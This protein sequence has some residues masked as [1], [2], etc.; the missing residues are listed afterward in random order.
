ME[1]T[2][3]LKDIKFK[4]NPDNREIRSISHD[5]RH[6]N[7]GALFIAI[8][9]GHAD[10]HDFIDDAIQSGAVAILSNGRNVKVKEV[11]LIRVKDPRAAMSHISANFYNHPSRKMKI[12]GVTG[13]NGKTSITHIVNSI[14]TASGKKCGTLGTLGFVTPSGIISTGFTTPESVEVQH[15]LS[16]LLNGGIDHA[17]M[18]I[19]SHAL[20]FNRVDDVDVDV[21][22]FTNLTPEHLDFHGN[23]NTYFQAKLKLFKKLPA[24]KKGVINVDDPCGMKIRAQTNAEIISFGFDKTA[25]IHPVKVHYSLDGIAANLKVK[26]RNLKVESPLIGDYNLS[27]IMASVG[28]GI[29]FDLSLKDIRS[30]IEQL[31]LIPGRMEKI[32]TSLQGD[33]FVDYAHTPDAFTKIFH[34][35]ENLIQ[36]KKEIITVFG[37]GGDRD[38]EKRPVMAGIAENFSDYVFVTSDNPRSEKL[39]DII[40]DICVGFKKTNHSVVFNRKEAI[41][42]AI[43]KSHKDSVILLLGKGRDDYEIIGQEKLFHSDIKTVE[44]YAG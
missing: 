38:A 33:F 42:Q 8:S 39:E 15:L 43:H 34:T 22:V 26:N 3:V 35:V 17:V 27:N 9:G 31:E 19:S 25:D 44:N 6:V 7:D 40:N 28:V 11:P 12:A 24:E 36:G 41:H 37:C 23:M 13:T 2:Q 18:E 29:A 30:G 21:A 1:L 20:E 14:L 32:Q 4:G 16:I 5:S 10:G